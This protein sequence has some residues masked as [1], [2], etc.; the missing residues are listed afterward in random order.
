MNYNDKLRT[1]RDIRMSD[2]WCLFGVTLLYWDHILTFPAEVKYLWK[3]PR[4]ISGYMFFLNRYFTALTNIVVII[5][6]LGPKSLLESS[7]CLPLQKIR[8]IVVVVAQVI[9]LLI[10]TMRIYALYECNKRLLW[11]LLCI[12]MLGLAG[13]AFSLFYKTGEPVFETRCHTPRDERQAAQAVVAW[14]AA[15][16]YDALIFS[17]AM[18]KAYQ[19]KKQLGMRLPLMTIIIRDGSL[20]FGAMSLASLANILTFYLAGPFMKVSLSPVAS[21]LSVTLVSRLM[22]HLHEMADTGIYHFSTWDGQGIEI[23][24]QSY[25]MDVFSDDET[26]K[27]TVRL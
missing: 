27:R 4:A 13:C 26:L 19:T 5:S 15:F 23:R 16:F 3:R 17:L 24:V 25:Q 22:L 12:L 20:Y 9:V 11:I 1:E 14:E 7:S 6:R 8:D 18:Y 2:Y 10:M 21:S